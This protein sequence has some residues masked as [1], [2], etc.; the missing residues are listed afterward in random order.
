MSQAEASTSPRCLLWS[1]TTSPAIWTRASSA[2]ADGIARASFVQDKPGCPMQCQPWP[3]GLSAEEVLLQLAARCRYSARMVLVLRR[4]ATSLARFS[5][6]TMRAGL[7]PAATE[8]Q[9]LA[10]Q[11]CAPG[12]T[13]RAAGSGRARAELPHPQPRA[14]GRPPAGAA[15]GA[16]S[17][18]QEVGAGARPSLRVTM[19]PLCRKVGAGLL[20]LPL[21]REGGAIAARG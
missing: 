4:S 6:H 15:A 17:S 16:R 14:P 5:L 8:H 21:T 11:I 9:E 13:H 2:A 1:T 7:I 19:R 18:A 10:S 12:G 3:S 20:T